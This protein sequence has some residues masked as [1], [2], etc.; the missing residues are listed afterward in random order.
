MSNIQNYLLKFL[1]VLTFLLPLSVYSY[2][3]SDYEYIELNPY[4]GQPDATVKQSSVEDAAVATGNQVWL[5]L[6][7]SNDPLT[8]TLSTKAILPAID[9]TYDLGSA[10]REWK[11]IYVD[12]TAYIDAISGGAGVTEADTLDTVADRGSTT[13]QSITTGGLTVT[14]GT[15]ITVGT[16]QWNS[17]DE[18]DGTKIKDA[19]YGDVTIDAAGDWDVENAQT[20][21]TNANLT[22][23]I[24]S[25]GNATSIASQ[26]GTG[27]K[28]VVDNTPTLVTPEIGVATGTSLQIGAN[29]LDTNEWAFLDGQDQA[30]KIAS[31]PQFAGLGI[32]V[33]GASGFLKHLQSYAGSGYTH[34][35]LPAAATTYASDKI[36]TRAS[37]DV[38]S[39][40]LGGSADGKNKIAGLKFLTMSEA[41]STYGARLIYANAD[42]T[43]LARGL[44]IIEGASSGTNTATFVGGKVGIG[45]T[46][47]Q[48]T[49]E[50]NGTGLFK[51]KIKFTQ[52]DGNEYIDSLNNGYMDYGATTGHRFYEKIYLIEDTADTASPTLYFEG[53]NTR[54]GTICQ[55]EDAASLSAFVIDTNGSIELQTD[56]VA[57]LTIGAGGAITASSTI[58]ATGGFLDNNVAGID[59]TFLDA[60][61]NTITVS[62]GIIVSKVAP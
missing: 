6:D 39:L 31:I 4:S 42:A 29:T 10:T 5:Q 59:T 55:K 50:V 36:Y 37:Y 3:P 52:D 60:D 57:R 17:A 51:D 23:V 2:G 41:A 14:T 33:A 24:T 26:T 8:D 35:A 46:N 27:T 19:D 21:T 47:P 30:V 1:L 45:E 12:G 49:L 13:D 15:H 43:G 40:G 48:D 11:D 22:G 44:H 54:R 28:F 58:D 56:S 7:C 62:G 53:G 9:N 32:G 34:L 38:L 61:G 18:F 16:T 25:I 20:V